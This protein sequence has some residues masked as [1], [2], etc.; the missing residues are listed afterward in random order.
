MA[1]ADHCVSYEKV[2]REVSEGSTRD[3]YPR[4][5]YQGSLGRRC[6]CTRRL[7]SPS[8]GGWGASQE[9]RIKNLISMT[10]SPVLFRG[11]LIKGDT[12]RG[13]YIYFLRFAAWREIIVSGVP[14][15]HSESCCVTGGTNAVYREQESSSGK[16]F[17]IRHATLVY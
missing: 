14:D 11:F 7:H 2:A 12:A 8:P 10:A 4:C 17:H 16:H 15:M 6:H 1:P 3:P 9:S 5:Q 13:Y